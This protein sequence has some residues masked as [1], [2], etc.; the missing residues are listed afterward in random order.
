MPFIGNLVELNIYSNDGQILLY[1]GNDP[2][3]ST[4][5]FTVKSDGIY[6]A[7]DDACYYTYAGNKIFIGLSI[8]ANSKQA[9]YGIGTT[10]ELG[11]HGTY[12]I[13]EE[14]PNPPI[15][16][17]YGCGG[18]GGTPD[19]LYVWKKY[20]RAPIITFTIAGVSYQAE[21]GMTWREWISSEYNTGGYKTITITNSGVISSEGAEIHGIYITV[22]PN[23]TG[24]SGNYV[25]RLG[26]SEPISS[27]VIIVHTVEYKTVSYYI[28]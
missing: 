16:V 18:G 13:V 26:Q 4:T 17:W 5:L 2:I 11:D 8:T 22:T 21:E 14:D 19:G 15:N 3:D 10:F 24:D 1:G 20:E 12:Y 23:S 6:S 27:D 7:S 25:A 9:N 28:D